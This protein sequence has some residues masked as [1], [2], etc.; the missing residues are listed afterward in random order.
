MSEN[1][2]KSRRR[3]IPAGEGQRLVEEL[4][5]IPESQIVPPGILTPADDP[6]EGVSRAD[7]EAMRRWNEEHE[8]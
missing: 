5:V 2:K 8:M 7:V 1:K 6:A 3:T 4:P